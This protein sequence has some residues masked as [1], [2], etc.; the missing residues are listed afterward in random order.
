M[1]KKYDI[2]DE[3]LGYRAREEET[4]LKPGFLVYPS[5][6]VITNVSGRVQSVP[7]Y[8][9]DGD[10]SIVSDNG[11]QSRY[12]FDSKFDFRRNMRAGGITELAND[13]KLQFRYKDAND[14]VTWK[15]I[16]TG[17]TNCR[18]SYTKFWDTGES[19]NLCLFAN[20]DGNIYE[21]NGA[22]TE[23]AS[24]G[25]NTLTKSGANT[26]ATDGF[27]VARN[28]TYINTRTGVEFTS[29]GGEATMILTG[30]TP[31]PALADIQAGDVF[32][33]K[34]VTNAVSGF[35]GPTGIT[36]Y[37]PTVLGTDT[38]N[39][40][41]MGSSSS[42]VC[43]VSK[44]SDFSDFAFSSPLRLSGEGNQFILYAPVRAFVSQETGSTE[45]STMLISAGKDYWYREIT[46]TQINS[47]T[48][49]SVE[50]VV[51]KPLRT[52][53]LQ[54]AFTEG[55]V[56][57]VKNGIA[58]L[59]NDAVV[60]I[61][62]QVS[63]Q[64]VPEMTDISYT[65]VNDMVG[66]D[67]TDANIFYHR[68]FIYLTVPRHGIIRAYN[69][70]NPSSQYWEAPIGYP[71][72]SFYVTD[73]GEIGGHGYATSESYLLFTGNRFRANDTDEG[74]P[75]AAIAVFP[76]YPHKDRSKTKTS[77]ELYIDGYIG[78][79]TELTAGIICN[80]DGCHTTKSKMLSG[81]DTVFVCPVSEGGSFGDSPFGSQ[82]LGDGLEVANRPPF[83][84]WIPTWDTTENSYRFEQVF[85]SSYGIDYQWEII[86]FGSDSKETKE[87]NNDIKD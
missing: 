58:F 27:Y 21:W 9:V 67:F 68:N 44:V 37:K 51:L 22:V 84:N 20:G 29:T 57:K 10:E 15:D 38:S 86:A 2:V 41:W 43:Y 46:T 48:G 63:N 71:V 36:T 39:Q 23:I 56:T 54:G 73:D 75:I 59:G 72:A 42:N 45:T 66:Y 70:T 69:M 31:D 25:V 81:A 53:K 5:Q 76:P 8:K 52:G 34:P 49:V 14:V 6:N 17:L 19:V 30:V 83:F 65:I 4:K 7:G 50:T 11:I 79:T 3:I 28:R 1:T 74:F 40:L 62:G 60:N 13:G 55:V 24:G 61:L 78:A 77:Q 87:D 33:Q 85:F 35:A 47:T 64:Y 80:I 18:F 82:I 12:D 32:I 26:W 16:M